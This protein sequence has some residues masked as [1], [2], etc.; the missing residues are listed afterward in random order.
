M[1]GSQIIQVS[2]PRKWNNG[3]SNESWVKVP[4]LNTSSAQIGISVRV[5]K[6][7][8]WT[9]LLLAALCHQRN[10]VHKYLHHSGRPVVRILLSSKEEGIEF[11]PR[12]RYRFPIKCNKYLPVYRYCL[13]PQSNLSYMHVPGG[14]KLIY[15][16]IKHMSCFVNKK[17]FQVDLY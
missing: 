15:I 17:A 10:S 8:I 16:I 6:L 2:S 11:C 12:V 9:C 3:L 13:N 5:R 4:H 14:I 1:K 7:Y